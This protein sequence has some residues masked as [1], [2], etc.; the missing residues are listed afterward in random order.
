NNGAAW[1]Q[2]EPISAEQPTQGAVETVA[3]TPP[4]PQTPIEA[5]S[6]VYTVPKPVEQAAAAAGEYPLNE[7]CLN[8]K[9]LVAFFHANGMPIDAA[10]PATDG[11]TATLKIEFYLK[12]EVTTGDTK[13]SPADTFY[14]NLP[15]NLPMTGNLSGSAIDETG[16]TVMR[17]D[18]SAA[19]RLN[20]HFTD[21]LFASN[22]GDYHGTIKFT[23]T[24]NLSDGGGGGEI[25]YQFPGDVTV[26]I[27][28]RPVVDIQ[29]AIV[30]NVYYDQQT[31]RFY[32]KYK[33]DI[34]TSI[35]LSSATVVDQAGKWVK[36]LTDTFLWDG[37]ALPAGSSAA[38][39]RT[40]D[41]YAT[42]LT[43]G[44]LKAD[45]K[46]TLTYQAEIVPDSNDWNEAFINGLIAD[47]KSNDFRTNGASLA[48]QT[49]YN[50]SGKAESS[51]VTVTY[52]EKAVTLEMTNTKN[53]YYDAAKKQFF[54]Q[55]ELTLTNSFALDTAVFT[56]HAGKWVKPDLAT[57]KLDGAAM[58]ASG[59]AQQQTADGGYQTTITLNALPAGKHTLVY[60]AQIVPNAADWDAALLKGGLKN[61]TAATVALR[62]NTVNLAWT[63]SGLAGTVGPKTA[64]I[65]YQTDFVSIQKACDGNVVFYEKDANKFYANYTLTFTTRFALTDATITDHAGKWVKPINSSFTLDSVAVPAARVTL[66]Q[67]GSLNN[68]T[69]IALGALAAGTHILKYRAEIVPISADW[70]K[71][72]VEGGMKSTDAALLA[73][74]TNY[75]S[76]AW[77]ADNGL[78]GN[79]DSNK[80]TVKYDLPFVRPPVKDWTNNSIYYDKD[81]DQ[82][83]A[84]YTVKFS[85]TV[86]LASLIVTDTAGKWVQPQTGTFTLD[87]KALTGVTQKVQ[88]GNDAAKYVTTITL[89]DVLPGAHTIAYTAVIAPTAQDR[90]DAFGNGGMNSDQ[91]GTAAYRYNKASLSWQA[92]GASGGGDSNGE[93]VFDNTG[94][95]SSFRKNSTPVGVV[96]HDVANKRFYMNYRIVFR[97][98]SAVDSAI[99]TDTRHSWITGVDESSITYSPNTLV[100]KSV[101]HNGQ[102]STFDLGAL[103]AGDYTI[104]YRAFV[105]PRFLTDNI[106]TDPDGAS[107]SL[108]TA[109][110]KWTWKGL[111]GECND[112]ETFNVPQLQLAKSAQVTYNMAQGYANVAW[113]LTLNYGAVNIKDFVLTDTLPVHHT[114]FGA[115]TL[116]PASGTA[117]II[118]P[119]KGAPGFTNTPSSAEKQGVFTYK[120]GAN[121]EPTNT[122]YTITYT[123]RIPVAQ[124]ALD[125]GAQPFARY[126]NTAN[127]K[128]D[129]YHCEQTVTKDVD[130]KP[131]S[132]APGLQKTCL[133]GD[134]NTMI[135]QW[136]SDVTVAMYTT[137]TNVR[138]VD[139]GISNSG[140]DTHKY[141]WFDP[142]D[143]VTVVYLNTDGTEGTAVDPASYA[144][145]YGTAR[146]G[147]AN[148][149]MTLQWKG[150][151]TRSIRMKYQTHCDR[152]MLFLNSW[153]RNGYQNRIKLYYDQT[154]KQADAAWAPALSTDL[155]DISKASKGVTQDKKIIHWE[156][157]G[158]VLRTSN[159]LPCTLTLRDALPPNTAYVPG[160]LQIVLGKWE[161]GAEKTWKQEPVLD[162]NGL[163]SVTFDAPCY[164]D[165]SNT[166]YAITMD[167]VVDPKLYEDGQAHSYTFT[168]E[169]TLYYRK[170]DGTEGRIGTAGATESI[171][172]TAGSVLEKTV[173]QN[174]AY[175]QYKINI[176]TMATKLDVGQVGYL[177]LEDTLQNGL[178][179]A[180]ESVTV[181]DG[182][183]GNKLAQVRGNPGKNEF[184]FV[185]DSAARKLTVKVPDE[186]FCVLNFDALLGGVIGDPVK[187][188][189]SITL[190]GKGISS[191]TGEKSFV[192]QE[193]SATIDS[194]NHSLSIVKKDA[195]AGTVITGAQ[196]AVYLV[197]AA[198]GSLINPAVAIGDTNARG[199][200]QLPNGGGLKPDTLYCLKE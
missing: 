142:A 54:A 37:A 6:D 50:V 8:D 32:A 48:W 34:Q 161:G 91:S 58:D 18:V 57:F 186:Q 110:L 158:K 140:I 61:G 197:K 13:K 80:V 169:A 127:V 182:F 75:A 39:E 165:P 94:F 49:S 174:G 71:A 90:I 200:V 16:A 185:Y 51:K 100:P 64:V 136:Q 78:S 86:K 40:A 24:L 46:H 149:Q 173:G 53:T 196:F 77:T 3:P 9:I 111:S 188:N 145:T 178:I 69:T 36:P 76:F 103:E 83:K 125:M 38:Q 88:E 45:G 56:D 14:V 147:I 130:L 79:K 133:G 172:Y 21:V 183:T 131:Q 137:L 44:A 117:L 35:N 66:T 20:I 195:D 179:I 63:G 152:S 74:R 72:F 163:L 192:V 23:G 159:L 155:G 33:L 62:T 106:S 11:E 187:V 115:I 26:K 52:T 59:L 170:P 70:Q 96:Q 15:N 101:S 157:Q 87:G 144:I 89:T 17:F 166:Y 43:L 134:W 67:D 154:N 121:A 12:A 150:T 141:M 199:E 113:T 198:N 10:N 98:S 176:N 126:T 73:Y 156:L 164:D 143:P 2:G 177:N 92:G 82:F 118:D 30:T 160:T 162:E 84:N 19:N 31:K 167:T 4:A 68:T 41:G 168:N 116:T 175:L 135:A 132:V 180:A 65:W 95:V 93:T 81:A 29:K 119:A 184:S 47:V 181:K 112:W 108:N 171:Q 85:N 7:W 139:A 55:Y 25:I 191:S 97:L 114:L 28:V 104:S 99:I 128:N 60:T 194:A 109:V 189:N 153:Y 124:V 151:L 129:D 27:P 148:S 138:L 105:D 5:V 146:G 1:A 193:P 107:K 102:V 42:T 22:R 190:T 123:T 122:S 120:F